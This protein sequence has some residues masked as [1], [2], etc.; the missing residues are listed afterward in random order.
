MLVFRPGEKKSSHTGY[1]ERN[2]SS[3]NQEVRKATESHLCVN[4]F[5]KVIP[6]CV[7]MVQPA[8]KDPRGITLSIPPA[9]RAQRRPQKMC[10]Q[11]GGD[12]VRL[13]WDVKTLCLLLSHTF[14]NNCEVRL[15]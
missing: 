5:V 6:A 14:T 12:E 7:T 2:T 3:H 15:Y 4:V 13:L 10:F 8:W 9:L 1:S 11:M